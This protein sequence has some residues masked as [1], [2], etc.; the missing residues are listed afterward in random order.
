LHQASASIRAGAPNHDEDLVR[1]WLHGR[2]VNT[3]SAYAADIEELQQLVAAPISAITLSDLQRF[4]DSIAG[5]SVS[6]RRRKLA[7]AKSLLSFAA[8]TGYIQ[9]NVG[10]AL[11]L[12]KAR[13]TL[14][15]RIMSESDVMAMLQLEKHPRNRVI[16]RVLYY[17]GA[18]VS[19]ITALRWADLVARRNPETL[20]ET[21]QTTL[22]GKGGK[23]RHV[24][25]DG[26]TWRM[27]MAIRPRV[28]AA[29]A[30]VFRSRKTGSGLTRQQVLRIV[31]AAGKRAGVEGRVSPHWLRHSHATHALDRGAPISLVASTLG[32]ASAAVTSRY[33]HVRPGD[34]SGRYLPE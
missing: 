10:A 7:S 6:T 16:V 9:A 23:T 1:L 4:S 27:L 32:H 14:S 31:C 5:S 3:Q 17:T 30:P 13:D 20:A 22:F 2:P 15:E 26:T 28:A 33:L 11:Q 8:K 34:S 19:E 24:L 21:G 18:R 12:P 25:L 29:D